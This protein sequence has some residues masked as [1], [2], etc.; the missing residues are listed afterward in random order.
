MIDVFDLK[1]DKAKKQVEE[2]KIVGNKYLEKRL[3][4]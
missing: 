4:K 1:L 3:G 2:I